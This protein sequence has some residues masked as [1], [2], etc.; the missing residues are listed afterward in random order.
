MKVLFPNRLLIGL[1]CALGATPGRAELKI[2]SKA[3]ALS[4]S[5]WIKGSEVNIA[6]SAG[7]HSYLI[8]FWA[9]WCPPCI[10]S[11]PHLTELQ[12]KYR[13]KGLI[14]IGATG[15][16]RGETLS[17]V[18]RFV[19]SR[20]DAMDYTVAYDKTG[21]THEQ[22]MLAARAGGIPYAF[23]VDKTGNLV[24]HGHPGDPV[25]DEIIGDV[26]AGTYDVASAKL[27][28]QLGPIFGRMHRLARLRDW[29]SFKM[30]IQE[31]LRLDP[32]NEAAFGAMVYAYVIETDDPDGL[33]ALA[34]KH[35][36]A[37]KSDAKAMAT[38]ASALMQIGDLEKRHPALALKAAARAYEACQQSDSEMIGAY[39]R[40]V[41]EIGLVDR[42]IT[43][44]EEAVAVAGDSDQREV[45]ENILKYYKDCKALHSGKL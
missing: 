34:E 37:H 39:A 18:K 3:P 38:L 26:V 12:R 8:E 28:E 40:A 9:T 41:F 30:Q 11:I 15:P 10:A 35:I 16:G 24:W 6:K 2:G 5:D 27:R 22:Y 17:K 36:E 43:L 1:I 32:Q 25:M 31:I 20:G 14:V 4:F 21:K 42:A 7:Q 44:Q 13:D 33:G 45:Q 19:S 23:L 29:P